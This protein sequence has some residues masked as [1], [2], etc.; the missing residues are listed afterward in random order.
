[1]VRVSEL[2]ERVCSLGFS[3]EKA[4]A[5][6]DAS[7]DDVLGFENRKDFFDEEEISEELAESIYVGFCCEKEGM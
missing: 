3:A 7:L 5:G 6:I 1:M 2:I 4:I